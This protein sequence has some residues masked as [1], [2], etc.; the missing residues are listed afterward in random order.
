[1]KPS[2][3]LIVGT[4]FQNQLWLCTLLISVMPKAPISCI[5]FIILILLSRCLGY[6]YISI[7]MF[8]FELGCKLSGLQTEILLRICGALS[9]MW[10]LCSFYAPSTIAV[11]MFTNA[12]IIEVELIYTNNIYCA[13]NAA[14]SY[15]VFLFSFHPIKINSLLD[16]YWIPKVQ[17]HCE[18]WCELCISSCCEKAG[19]ACGRGDVLVLLGSAVVGQHRAGLICR[20]ARSTVLWRFLQYEV[21]LTLLYK[22]S[23]EY[24]SASVHFN[25]TNLLI[26][27]NKCFCVP[28]IRVTSVR[29]SSAVTSWIAWLGWGSRVGEWGGIVLNSIFPFSCF[30]LWKSH[31]F[32]PSLAAK[33][34]LLQRLSLQC[35]KL[36]LKP[37]CVK[38]KL[39]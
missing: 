34:H 36:Y 14:K 5:P 15:Q 10:L 18:W 13:S 4:C 3:I 6:L 29:V 37:W 27:F 23:A 8:Q 1:M 19:A 9:T 30:V 7:P 24:S 2:D 26:V 20:V 22:V 16:L 32:L 17:S 12:C 25:N 38:L 31:C 33:Q 39:F 28:Q 21:S 11:K 35:L